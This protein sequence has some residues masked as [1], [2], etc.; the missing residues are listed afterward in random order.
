M[1]FNPEGRLEDELFTVNGAE[2]AESVIP[3]GASAEF[4]VKLELSKEAKMHFS[5][6]PSLETNTEGSPD[7]QVKAQLDG[8]LKWD[9]YSGM[10]NEFD[11]QLSQGIHW[12]TLNVTVPPGASFGD[13]TSVKTVI[14]S[15]GTSRQLIIR[16]AV[17]ASILAV[18][19]AIGQEKEVADSIAAKAKEGQLGI[20]SILLPSNIRGY[21]FIEA[22]N[23]EKIENAV[24]GIRKTHGLVKGETSLSEITHF[25]TPKPTVSG[26]VEGDIVELI[27]GPFKGE[28]A[29]VQR[30]DHGKEEI[31]V[32]LFEAVVPIPVTV[33]GDHVRVIEK[34]K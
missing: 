32:E 19:T 31:T 33:R 3:V 25:L 4:P 15:Q 12:F 20:Y 6:S 28:K 2:G 30:I 1:S 27:A 17:R 23:S 9:S 26:I 34:E 16:V 29:R 7:W 24:K 11:V 21:V 22:M 5:I 18:K 13:A 8:L 14:S 10:S